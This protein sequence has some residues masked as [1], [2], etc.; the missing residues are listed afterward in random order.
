MNKAPSYKIAGIALFISFP[1]EISQLYQALWINEIRSTYPGHVILWSGFAM[2][3]LVA[4]TVGA[5]LACIT[6][7]GV[8]FIRPRGGSWQKFSGNS[9]NPLNQSAAAK[10]CASSN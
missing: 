6:D 1:D 5:A 4:Y 2:A 8:F 7:Q 3:E 10:F 9:G